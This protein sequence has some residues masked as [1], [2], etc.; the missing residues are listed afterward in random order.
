L[1]FFGFMLGENE[2]V[3]LEA[4]ALTLVLL[5]YFGAPFMLWTAVVGV[6]LVGF[7]APPV[8]I[9]IFLLIAVI[10]N[11]R[12]LRT[13][14]F[15]LPILKLMRSLQLVPKISETERTALEAGVV[16]LDAEL[17]SGKPNFKRI[18]NEPY[19]LLTAKDKE[20]VD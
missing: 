20:V 3:Y 17:F 5:G 7:D 16:W 14:I 4:T 2:C 8:V 1:S 19:P 12:P 18:I 6:A 15:S 13:Y 11:I 9:G 10:G